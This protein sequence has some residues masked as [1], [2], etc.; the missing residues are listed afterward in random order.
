MTKQY[1]TSIDN[2]LRQVNQMNGNALDKFIKFKAQVISYLD[3]REKEVLT[4]LNSI[5]DQ[6]TTALEKLKPTAN[7]IQA[8]LN[9][10]QSKLRIHEDKSNKLFVEA[11]RAR[12]LF[13][14]LQSSLHAIKQE[15]GNHY[16]ELQTDL[17][18]EKLLANEKELAKVTSIAGSLI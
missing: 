9:E 14:T 2:M 4:E 8:D 5:L 6:D 16:V 15:T 17:M 11:K 12:T 10:A 1:I 7:M 18:V 13:A 3:Q